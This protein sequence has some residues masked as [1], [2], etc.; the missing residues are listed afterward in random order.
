MARVQRQRAPSN[1]PY[2]ERERG[3]LDAMK[4]LSTIVR[5]AG[6]ERIR[7]MVDQAYKGAH[8]GWSRE[9]HLRMQRVRALA[10]AAAV[11][12]GM[13]VDAEEALRANG[14]LERM[15]DLFGGEEA[16]EAVLRAVRSWQQHASRKARWPATRQA[17][18]HA[19]ATLPSPTS[20][21]KDWQKFQRLFPVEKSEKQLL[22]GE[23]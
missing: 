19:E 23:N 13:G 1:S 16:K 15:L 3:I 9:R 7:T 21:E 10:T 20:L 11:T 22:P 17:L 18:A 8:G 5:W 14:L 6:P 2:D 12:D 4:T